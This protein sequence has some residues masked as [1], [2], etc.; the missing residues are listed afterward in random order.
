M[1]HFEV[2]SGLKMGQ[3]SVFLSS[4]LVYMLNGAAFRGV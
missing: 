1:P 2:I 3:N 4:V